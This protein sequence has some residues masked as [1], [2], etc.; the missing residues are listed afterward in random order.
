MMPAP[1]DDRGGPCRGAF[2]QTSANHEQDFESLFV[3]L[4]RRYCS[5]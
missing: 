2:N 3:D 1:H 4:A 5:G